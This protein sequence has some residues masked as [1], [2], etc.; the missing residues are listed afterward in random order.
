MVLVY[1]NKIL[2]GDG[3][4]SN[5]LQGK[6]KKFEDESNK[7]FDFAPNKKYKNIWKNISLFC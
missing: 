5:Q 7:R 4:I 1:P 6:Q 3:T 2:S